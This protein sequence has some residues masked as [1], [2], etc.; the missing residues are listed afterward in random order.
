MI[1][2]KKS[3]SKLFTQHNE[4]VLMPFSLIVNNNSDKFGFDTL[5]GVN[6]SWKQL[7]IM[8]I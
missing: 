2:A 4:R 6:N 8:W 1:V 3:A 7:E 5:S